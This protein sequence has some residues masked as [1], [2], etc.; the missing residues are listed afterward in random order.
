M[1]PDGRFLDERAVT[2]TG[3]AFAEYLTAHAP[4]E[5]AKRPAGGVTIR[6]GQPHR[7]GSRVFK[8]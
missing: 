4:R 8:L 3:L 6:Y 1:W 7:I 2:K 5:Q